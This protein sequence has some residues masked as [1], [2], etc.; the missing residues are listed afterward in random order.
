LLAKQHGGGGMY[1]RVVLEVEP[2]ATDS[3]IVIENRVTGGAIPTEFISACHLGIAIAT[4]KGVLGH[5]VIGVKATL[6]DGK[7]HS[8][9]SNGMS[10][11]IAAEA[12]AI[13]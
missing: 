11:Q 12:K 3:G 8:D 7:A 13:G 5:P 9:D 4:S 6:L 2:G 1:A 10:F